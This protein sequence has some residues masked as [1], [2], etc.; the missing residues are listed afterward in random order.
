MV[1]QIL[2]SYSSC[3]ICSA[4]ADYSL[5][6]CC[7]DKSFIA[8]LIYV[9]DILITSNDLKAIYT[10]K[11]FL[12]SHFSIKDLGDFCIVISQKGI[13]ISQWKY[14]LEILKDSGIL[15]AKP[16]NFPMEQNKSS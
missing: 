12:H 13:S 9:D 10:L 1:C 15:G 16:M 2:N 6:T 3:R 7:N 11:R 8:L 14:I 4:K 5:F